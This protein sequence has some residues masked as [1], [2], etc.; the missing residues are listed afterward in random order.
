V[1]KDREMNNKV[2]LSEQCLKVG[3]IDGKAMIHGF[4]KDGRIIHQSIYCAKKQKSFPAL[5]TIN[6]SVSQFEKY[7]SGIGLAIHDKNFTLPLKYIAV[8]DSEYAIKNDSQFWEE[9]CKNDLFDIWLPKAPFSFF[10]TSKNDSQNKILL[11]RIYEINEE[12]KQSDIKA[13][14]DYYD[15]IKKLNREVTIKEPIISDNE[16]ERIKALLIKSIG[17]IGVKKNYWI[18]QANPKYYDIDQALQDRVVDFKWMVKRYK[19][20]IKVGDVGYIWKSGSDGGIVA[21]TEVIG[22]PKLYSGEEPEDVPRVPLEIKEVLERPILRSDLTKHPILSNLMIIRSPQGTNYPLTAE[23]AKSIENLINISK[24]RGGRNNN[25]PKNQILYGP[26]GT[27]KTYRTVNHA[28][29]IIEKMTLTDFNSSMSN[30]NR[31]ELTEK[32]KQYKKNGQI[33]FITFHQNYAYEDFIQGLRPD[34]NRAGNGL[35]FEKKD[36]VFKKIADRALEEYKSVKE[37]SKNY[38]LIID[39]I[40]RANISRVFGELITLIEE[41][42][43]YGQVNEMEATLPSGDPFCIPPNLY[44]IGTMNTA[45]KSIALLDIALRRRFE[46]IKV[47]PVTELVDKQFRNLFEKLNLQIRKEKGP[48]FQIGHAYLM[49]KNGDTPDIKEVMNNKIIPLLYEY[50]MNDGNAVKD[51]L[52]E[53]GIEVEENCGLCECRSYKNG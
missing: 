40:N 33:E 3:K 44:I 17:I 14:T 46:F 16:F 50:F 25:H 49:S 28:L 47:Y 11:L 21:V 45:D 32:F 19:D 48:D 10:S 4:E 23:E 42:K 7:K 43:R 31:K 27:G 30:K 6:K 26:P 15:V 53:S 41:D 13:K 20:R 39:E 2:T 12:F 1:T 5:I 9:V 22:N 36:G 34:V 51:I 52:T 38:V 29:S 37:K 35:S 24:G 18:F 8:V